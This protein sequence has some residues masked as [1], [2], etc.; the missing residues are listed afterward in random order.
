[1]NISNVNVGIKKNK[2]PLRLGRG[3]GTGQGKTAGRGHK[4]FGSRNGSSMNVSFEGGQMPLFRRIPKRGFN[5][6][7]AAKV[8]NINVCDIDKFFNEGE[9]VSP[10]TLKTKGLIK[11]RYDVLK[12]LGDGELTKKVK[13]QA[14]RFSKTAAEK[15]QAAGSEM[16]VLPGKAPL[17]KFQ[18]KAKA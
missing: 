17:V 9:V 12:V 14:H 8:A 11:Y 15:I 6:A 1:M 2:K 7:G 13:V 16:E 3:K 18:K 10:E 4:G 5:N